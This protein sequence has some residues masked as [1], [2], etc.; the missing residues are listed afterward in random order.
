MIHLPGTISFYSL[1]HLR[2]I[3]NAGTN[4]KYGSRRPEQA[5]IFLKRTVRA[6]KCN[7]IMHQKAKITEG[8]TNQSH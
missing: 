7:H 6:S 1:N 4:Y 2:E 3:W 8:F 5:A